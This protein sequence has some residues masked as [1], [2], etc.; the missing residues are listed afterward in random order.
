MNLSEPEYP[1]RADETRP[2]PINKPARKV[3]PQRSV[4]HPRFWTATAIFSLVVN[5]IL[6][7]VVV[8]LLT[9]V[10]AIKSAIQTGL[11]DPLYENFVRMDEARIQTT[12]T[13]ETSVPAKFDLPLSTDTTVILSQDTAIS[14]ANVDINTGSLT[15]NAPADIILPAGT[16]LPIHLTLSVPVDQ[17]IP[18][19]LTV[20]VD[21]PLNQTELHTPFVGLRDTVAPYRDLLNQIPSSWEE[22]FCGINPSHFC[23]TLIP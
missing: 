5:V 17:Q 12:V 7:I 2:T 6:V 1:A 3:T 21:I 19:S 15:L 10:F 22:V 18:V 20:P 9:Q 13:V 11:I 16:N 14:N 23:A 8:V 4:Y